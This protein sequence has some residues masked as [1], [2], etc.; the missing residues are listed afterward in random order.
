M[1]IKAKGQQNRVSQPE[2]LA[3]ALSFGGLAER[4]NAAGLQPVDGGSITDQGFESLT[5]LHFS[6]R[7]DGANHHHGGKRTAEAAR[8]RKFII[9]FPSV[10]LKA[11]RDDLTQLQPCR[12]LS[13]AIQ[14]WVAPELHTQAEKNGTLRQWCKRLTRLT[15]RFLKKRDNLKAALAPDFA[16]CDFCRIHGS[17]RIRPGWQPI[18][19]DRVWVMKI[20]SPHHSR[21]HGRRVVP[22]PIV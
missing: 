17:L 3:Q 6:L 10:N 1:S 5:R 14:N 16:H 22:T 9:G 2:L 7:S 12:M 11:I 20:S 13:A 19:T 15:L 18:L 4:S 21:L 8:I